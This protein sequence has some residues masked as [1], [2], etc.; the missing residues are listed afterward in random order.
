MLEIMDGLAAPAE[1]A[2]LLMGLRCRGESPAHIHAVV[3]AMLERC[4]PFVAP[5]GGP[6][7]DTCGTGGDGRNTVNIS[8]ATAILASTAGIPV[9]KH[10]NRSVSSSSGS[11]DVLEALGFNLKCPTPRLEEMFSSSDF[12]F[13][14]A[15]AFHP[16][17]KHAAPVRKELRLRTIF[18]LCGPLSNPA[19]P[20][21]Q[22]IGVADRHFIGPFIET[23]KL[24]GR[25]RALV[26]HG[27]DGLDEISATQVTVGMHLRDDGKI[28]DW[29]LDPRSLGL[30]AIETAA[31]AVEGPQQ[32]AELLLEVLS[33]AEG[34]V[35]DE[36]CLN[37]AAV[38]WLA[39]M[40]PDMRKA[41]NRAREIQR[42]GEGAGQLERIIA[43]SQHGA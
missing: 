12:T 35:A 8:T 10:G 15:P 26:V 19:R 18:N 9:C 40:E 17:M 13:L 25:K 32:S 29:H 38:I 30:A 3:R 42:S 5:P 34:P 43:A 1:I 22:L 31:L 36:I 14:F 28:E 11:A 39:D 7:F 2:A 16:A 37:L 21:H 41:F 20:T 27:V 33:G 24:L 6:I 4:A 23:L